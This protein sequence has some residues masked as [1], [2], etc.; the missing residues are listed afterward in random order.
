MPWKET[1]V[2]SQRIKFILRAFDPNTN[3]TELCSEFAVS[4]KTGYKWKDRF[5]QYGLPGLT[6][7]PRTPHSHPKRIS[8]DTICELIRIKKDKPKWGP[9][10]VR[11][12][13]DKNHPNE[14]VPCR[15]S[16]ERILKKSGYVITKRPKRQYRFERISNRFIP[17]HPNDLWTVDFKGWWYTSKKEKCEPLTVRDEFSKFIL[18]IKILDKGN[19]SCVKHE[20]EHLF[21]VYGLPR[22]IRSD[23]GPPF[24]CGQSLLGLTK[25]AAWWMSL[26]IQLDRIAP[27]SPYQNGAHERMHRD[28]KAELEGKING[29]LKLHQSIFNVWKDEFNRERPHEAIGMRTPSEL[30]RPSDRIYRGTIFEILYPSGVIPRKVN[31]RGVITYKGHRVFIT[32]AFCSYYLGLQLN[33]D[34]FKVWFGNFQLGEIDLKS[35]IFHSIVSLERQASKGTLK[36]LPM[37]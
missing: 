32:S 19:I 23:N 12:V 16:V 25:L 18:S 33:K 15:S 2:M 13:F 30:Y 1:N 27:A 3:F 11:L 8:E 20:F 6:D 24:A 21:T 22:A 9:K 17:T 26:G 14:Y 7:Q 5:L 35:F 4:T 34:F 10:K 28:M 29:D 31:N 36:V 37:F